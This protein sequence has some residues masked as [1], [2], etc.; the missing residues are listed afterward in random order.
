VI[1]RGVV[2]ARPVREVGGLRVPYVLAF[3]GELVSTP[4]AFRAPSRWGG[5]GLRLSYPDARRGDWRFGVLRAR[6]RRNREG[7]VRWRK[8]N[9][10]RQWRCMERA[11][12]QVCGG[13]ARDPAF[14]R[15]GWIITPTAFRPVDGLNNGGDTNQPATCA[16]CVPDALAMCPR[17]GGGA[18][19]VSVGEVEP[20]AVL[21]NVY[22]LGRG[23][24]AVLS[25]HNVYVGLDEF[26]RHPFV[27]ATQL[28]VRLY[29]IRPER[30]GA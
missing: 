3:S 22:R 23:G 15:V 13:D 28:V 6:V 18:A 7:E 26:A 11:R 29:D 30:A 12:C 2:A 21:A 17:L 27:L 24:V 14:G 8:V 20:V 9:T 19:V 4:V 25:G 16:G 1:R 5:G 10:F